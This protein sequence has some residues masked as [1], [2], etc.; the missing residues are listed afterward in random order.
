MI[1]KRKY[2]NREGARVTGGLILV[3]IGVALLLRNFGFGVNAEPF[4][5]LAK[6]LPF[7]TLFKH[8]NNLT[9]VDMSTLASG[10]YLVKVT[11]DNQVKTIKI[12]KR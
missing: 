12:N 6:H 11:S 1:D 8:A 9:Q 3:V 10:T 2:Q 5:L 4:E 7:T